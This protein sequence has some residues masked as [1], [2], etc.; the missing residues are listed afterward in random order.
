MDPITPFTHETRRFCR[1]GLAVLVPDE[2]GTG[3]GARNPI[4]SGRL[5]ITFVLPLSQS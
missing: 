1:D 4:L 3:E 5:H 2:F